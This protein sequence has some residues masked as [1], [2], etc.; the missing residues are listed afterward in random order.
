MDPSREEESVCHGKLT[1]VVNCHG[2]VGG[3]VSEG[4][5]IDAEVFQSCLNIAQE[6]SKTITNLI[7]GFIAAEKANNQIS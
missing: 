5:D 7:Q 4:L 2:E 1:I 6:K 3:L